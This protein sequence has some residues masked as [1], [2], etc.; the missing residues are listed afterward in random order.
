MVI[1]NVAPYNRSR[2]DNIQLVAVFFEKHVREM[3]FSKFFEI[4]IKDIKTLE[5]EGVVISK[6]PLQTVKGS[7]V[8]MVG[9]K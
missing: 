1:V 5:N 6:A 4:I 8:A 3:R 7:V 2:V 9:D